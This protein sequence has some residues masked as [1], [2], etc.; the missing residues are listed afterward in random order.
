[1]SWQIS[2]VSNPS[3]LVLKTSVDQY[4]RKQKRRRIEKL[5]LTRQ[6]HELNGIIPLSQE[7]GAEAEADLKTN[8]NHQVGLI[9]PAT[10]MVRSSAHLPRNWEQKIAVEQ[11][12]RK[13]AGV[14]ERL[15]ERVTIKVYCIL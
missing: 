5:L 11:C 12:W 10:R 13:W 1:M 14:L 7:A 3:Q 8:S 2:L 6:C 4:Y 15:W 9:W